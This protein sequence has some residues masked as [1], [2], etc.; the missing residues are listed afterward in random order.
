[1]GWEALGYEEDELMPGAGPGEWVMH[2]L[3]LP[4]KLLFAFIPPTDFCGG[5]LSFWCSLGMIAFVTAFVG[6]LAS[7][8]GCCLG[9]K[10]DV[11]A[12]TLVALGTSLPDTF[13]S[14]QAA[15]GDPYA[16]ASVG[17]VTGSNSVN[18]FL[19]LGLPWAMGSIYWDMGGMDS[20]AADWEKRK[21]ADGRTFM[22]LFDPP[23][24]SGLTQ[25]LARYGGFVVYSGDLA[26]SVT[27]YTALALTAVFFL[28]LRRRLYGGELGGTL[29]GKIVGAVFLT[30]LWFIY[31]ALSIVKS[32]NSS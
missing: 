28:L 15:M 32:M 4:W 10:D 21:I 25:E 6:D 18:V 1:M 27:V 14:K 23:S 30:S 9:L 12:I 2:G 31:L 24:G 16:D 17:N 19:G 5:W 22:D 26:Y 13:A 29:V 7:L 3:S 20:R 11:T 8:L